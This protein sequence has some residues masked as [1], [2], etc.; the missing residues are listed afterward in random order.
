MSKRGFFNE[1]TE[2]V[3]LFSI[4]NKKGLLFVLNSLLLF[5]NI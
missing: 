3:F 4:K 1:S 5:Q 2:E